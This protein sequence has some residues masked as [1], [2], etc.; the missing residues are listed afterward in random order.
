MGGTNKF[1][2]LSG[3]DFRSG[4]GQFWQGQ[5]FACALNAED[6]QPDRCADHGRLPDQG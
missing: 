4:V 6:G 2:A 3:V 1:D 5:A